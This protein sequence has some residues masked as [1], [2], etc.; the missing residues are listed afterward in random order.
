[1][2]FQAGY[3]RWGLLALAS[4]LRTVIAQSTDTLVPFA[5]KPL[6]LGSI[7]PA[8]WLK[9]QLTL[10]ANGLAG[11]QHDFYDFVAKSTWLG[12][13]SEYSSLREG[14][15]YWFNGL[16][17]LAYTL[18]D[19]R[20]LDQVH[21]A[22]DYVLQNQQEDGWLGPETGSERNFWGRM[23]FLLG[24]KGLAEAEKGGKWESRVVDSLWKFMEVTNSMLRDN[25]TGYHYHDGDQ[26][27]QGD[28]QW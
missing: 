15:P 7:K 27:G 10:S 17:P 11:H 9:D 8:G 5:F 20:L 26:V 14:F 13:T 18:E 19:E 16:V 25:F 23:P 2:H 24:L 12:G 1:M 21:T 22:A 28:E 4:P 6:P 3:K